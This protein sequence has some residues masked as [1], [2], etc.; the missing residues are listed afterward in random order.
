VLPLDL[1]DFYE[2]FEELEDAELEE[3]SDLLSFF[4]SDS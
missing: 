1:D 2:D 4:L 3:L